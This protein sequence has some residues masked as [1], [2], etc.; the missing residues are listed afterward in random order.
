VFAHGLR[1]VCAKFAL[2]TY[3]AGPITSISKLQIRPSISKIFDIG[4][5]LSIYSTSISKIKIFDIG[6]LRSSARY[7]KF[8][9]RY[10]INLSP[11]S[12]QS[13]SISNNF[14]I[15]TR[16]RRF[17]LRYRSFFDIEGFLSTSISKQILR[18]RSISKPDSYYIILYQVI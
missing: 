7:T 10:R 1:K 12:K 4:Y 6:Y 17:N 8:E 3:V 9:L 2:R 11:I 13:T 18:Y 16:Y 14:D 15:W 5:D